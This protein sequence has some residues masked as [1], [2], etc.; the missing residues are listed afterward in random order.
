MGKRQKKLT[1]KQNMQI[2][3]LAIYKIYFQDLNITNTNEIKY[4]NKNKSILIVWMTSLHIPI[5]H[6]SIAHDCAS[7]QLL[8][9]L[10]KL[11]DFGVLLYK[12]PKLY[13]LDKLES[14]CVE[15]WL[16]GSPLDRQGGRD[17]GGRG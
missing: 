14:G 9:V 1:L 6:G 16:E 4:A 2:T 10:N 8:S 12:T 11:L 15:A 3:E 5:Y 13:L 17:G 7:N